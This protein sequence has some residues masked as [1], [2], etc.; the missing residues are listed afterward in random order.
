MNAP[1]WCVLVFVF[2]LIG[3]IVYLV[4]RQSGRHIAARSTISA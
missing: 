1:F 2:M 4:R 3:G